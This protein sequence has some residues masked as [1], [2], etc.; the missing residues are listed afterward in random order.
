MYL[1]IKAYGDSK[2]TIKLDID[3]WTG[4]QY[5]LLLNHDSSISEQLSK[6]WCHAS[7]LFKNIQ[8]LRHISQFFQLGIC[9]AGVSLSWRSLVVTLWVGILFT[10]SFKWYSVDL[11]PKIS[12][13]FPRIFGVLKHY[14]TQGNCATEGNSGNCQLPV[15]IAIVVRGGWG[16][17]PFTV[18]N[19]NQM[20]A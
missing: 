11:W 13:W 20:K 5:Y 14:L 12:A 2:N 8:I 4:N 6:R 16:S 9:C 15:A 3:T 17:L 19:E 10:L 7:F 1:W 18:A